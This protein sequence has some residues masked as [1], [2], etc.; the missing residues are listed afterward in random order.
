MYVKGHRNYAHCTARKVMQISEH[1]VDL[2][3]KWEGCVPHI[4]KDAAGLP[5][6]GVGHLLTQKEKIGGKYAGGITEQQAKE[7]LK[8]DLR[9]FESLVNSRVTTPLE[10]H[11]YDALV[12]FV[13]NIGVAGFCS[14]SVL[15][16]INE[17]RKEDVPAAL[18][19]WNKIT[20]HGQHVINKGLVNRRENEIKLFMGA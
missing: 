3:T 17:N 4:Y 10:Q 13:F 2:L 20:I 18:R 1:G 5:T 8:T 9:R 6:I 7:L 19:L 14:S 16:A 11:E 15:R 12:I